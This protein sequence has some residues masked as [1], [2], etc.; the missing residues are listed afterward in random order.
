ML[1]LTKREGITNALPHPSSSMMN[2]RN[3]I[4]KRVLL[5]NEKFVFREIINNFNSLIPNY[6]LSSE[7]IIQEETKINFKEIGWKIV[8]TKKT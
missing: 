7:T 5:R 2:K 8:A 1:V 4:E 6:T 3:V